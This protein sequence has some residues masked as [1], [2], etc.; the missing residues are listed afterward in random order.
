MEHEFDENID[1][2]D[3]NDITISYYVNSNGS[4]LVPG[5]QPKE[6]PDMN[7]YSAIKLM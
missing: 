7:Y 2:I 5:D 4:D 1:S 3:I 6:I